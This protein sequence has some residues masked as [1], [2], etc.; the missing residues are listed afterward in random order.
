MRRQAV[1]RDRQLTLRMAFVLLLL[2]GMYL[3][4]AAVVVWFY[5]AEPGWAFDITL[6]ALPIAITVIVSA[7]P[8]AELFMDH[9]PLEKRLEALDEIAR[10]LGRVSGASGRG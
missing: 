2:A 10:R 8:G 3:A 7:H 1:G 5:R 9:P 6:F 4:F